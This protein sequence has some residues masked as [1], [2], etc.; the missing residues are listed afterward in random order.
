MAIDLKLETGQGADGAGNPL[1]PLR[2]Y[3]RLRE[4]RD[5]LILDA[6]NEGRTQRQI[7]I[8]VGLHI[9]SVKRILRQQRERSS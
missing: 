7:A 2:D 5:G 6:F 9:E 8:A 3:R 1:A 4:R